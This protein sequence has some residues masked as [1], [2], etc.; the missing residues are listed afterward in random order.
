MINISINNNLIKKYRDNIT[1]YEIIKDID[2]KMADNAIAILLDNML[3]DISRPIN[4]D[5]NIRI[6]T[7]NDL[8]GKKILWHSTAHILAESIKCLYPDAQLG[9]GPSNDNGFYYDIDFNGYQFN[10][11]K[12]IDIKN[13]MYELISLKSKYYRIESN[14]EEAKKYFQSIN[15]KYKLDILNQIYDKNITLYKHNNFIDLC[16]GPHINDTSFIK[17]VKLIKISGSYWRGNKNNQQLTRIYGIS[18]PNDKEMNYYFD[19]INKLKSKDHKKIGQQLNLFMFS[20]NVG[21]GLPLWLPKGNII[22]ERIINF[23]KKLQYV[24]NY[25]SVSTPHIAKDQLYKIS[26]HYQKYSDNIFNSIQYPNKNENYLLK[27]MNCPHHCE[28]YKRMFQ[29]YKSLPIKIS[30]FGTVYRYEQSGELNGLLRSRCFTQDD[31]HIFCTKNQL[32]QEFENVIEMTIHMLKSFNLFNFNVQLSLHDPKNIN[33]YIGS[34]DIWY[35]AEQCIIQACKNKNIKT[36]IIIGE[37][38]FYGPKLDFMVKDSLNRIWQLGTIQIDF[39]LPIRFELRYKDK[40]NKY[41]TPIMIHRAPLGSIERLI[42]LLLENSEGLL[43]FWLSPVQFTIISINNKLYKK[44]VKD[45]FDKLI[46]NDIY[47]TINDD[48]ETLSKKIRNAE[49]MK[50]PYIIIIGNKEFMNNDISIRDVNCK[51][52]Y[53]M[54]LDNFVEKVKKLIPKYI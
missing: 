26:G 10:Q 16:K 31:A 44:Y 34:K 30:E 19:N 18:F 29:S 4:N 6:L 24:N 45:I 23:I 48:N 9:I 53:N 52:Q 39:N 32:Q 3:W 33:N 54:S 46:N 49:I 14:F 13:K 22:K 42:A 20:E 2:Q 5:S 27:P 47:G 21:I 51:K 40:D 8:D 12:L 37:A 17:E 36:N 28:I 7:W 1:P 41:Y 11:S 38:A 25:I 43:P 50:I 15:E 35:L